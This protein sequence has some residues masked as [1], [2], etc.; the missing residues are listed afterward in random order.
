MPRVPYVKPALSYADQLQQLK[1]RGL[2]IG[3]DSKALH[4]LKNISYYRLSGYF[5]PMLDNPKSAQNFKPGSTFKNGFKLYCFDRELR[6][7]ILS[8]LEKI[9]VAVRAIMIYTLSHLHGPFWYSNPAIFKDAGKF[10][11]TLTKIQEEF[12]RSDEVFILEFKKKYLDPLP[13]SWMILEITSFGSLSMLYKNLLYPHDKRDIAHYF[14]L[15]DS[16]FES[17]LHSLAY[18][19]NVCAHHSRLWSR[20]MQISPNIPL[21]PAKQKVLKHL[22]CVNYFSDQ[23]FTLKCQKI[24]QKQDHFYVGQVVKTG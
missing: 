14:G 7:M 17:W 22:K 24:T 13:P 8:E 1:D 2:I 12:N 16:T 11:S 10:T 21:T 3:N 5:Y 18:V 4:L 9:E 23:Y 15:D 20:I 19:R 6:K